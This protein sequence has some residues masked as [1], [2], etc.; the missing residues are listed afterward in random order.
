MVV[1]LEMHFYDSCESC[2][3]LTKVEFCLRKNGKRQTGETLRL[4]SSSPS[5]PFFMVENERSCC[6]EPYGFVMYV[7]P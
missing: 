6:L 4:G 5:L 2:I 1:L 3:E 7:K